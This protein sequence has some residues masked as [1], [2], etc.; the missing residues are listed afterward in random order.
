MKKFLCFASAILLSLTMSLMFVGCKDSSGGKIKINEVTHSVFYA[1][2]YVAINKGY[3][4][5]YGIDV[6]LTN[7]GGSDASMTALLSGQADIALMGPETVVYVASQGSTSYPV[8]FGQLTKRDGSFLIS[9]SNY[10]TFNW[11]NDINGKTVIAGREGGL[12]A[13][14][15]EWVCGLN[16]LYN[17]LNVTLDTST[18][19]NMM[20]PVFEATDAEFCTM[21][22]PTASEFVN[23]GKGYNMGSVGQYSGEIPYT[24]F[25][26]KQSFLNKNEKLA[27]NFLKAIQKAYNFIKDSPS[28]EVA[29]ALQPSFE[30]T[31]LQSLALA[32][33]SYRSIDAWTNNPAMTEDSYVRLLQVMSNAGQ[34]T[35]N[36]AFSDVVDNSYANKI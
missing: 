14:T 19:F 26:A 1:P 21:F 8:V 20:V 13:M 22:E 28:S 18:A 33:E 2:L 15:F 24:C 35:T 29:I 23:A 27:I 32:V 17:N 11:Y 30:T 4:K 6:E 10:T 25:M 36:I 16:N 34:I 9:K 12:P 7:G 31:S 5:E 3:L